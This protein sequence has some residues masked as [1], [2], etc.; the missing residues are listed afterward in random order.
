MHGEKQCLLGTG[1]HS[2]VSF[3]LAQINLRLFVAGAHNCGREEGRNGNLAVLNCP[4]LECIM[5]LW[6]EYRIYAASADITEVRTS[7]QAG[8][9]LQT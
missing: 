3:T 1:C 4:V 7:D 8:R 2:G 5:F 6:N 9:Y